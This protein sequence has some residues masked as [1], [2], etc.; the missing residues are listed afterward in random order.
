MNVPTIV[1]LIIV[2]AAIVLA[3]HHVWKNRGKSCDGCNGGCSCNS[4]GCDGCKPK[5]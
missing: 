1:L 3:V 2:V 4:G 5:D